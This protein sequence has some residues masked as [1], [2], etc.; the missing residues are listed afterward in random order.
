MRT[1]EAR[2]LAP[3]CGRVFL[4][5]FLERQNEPRGDHPA[6]ACLRSRR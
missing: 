4:I 3:V 6:L 1:T 2:V 5:L